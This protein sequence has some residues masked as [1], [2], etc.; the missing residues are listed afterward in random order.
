MDKLVSKA[1]K[2]GLCY[3]GPNAVANLIDYLPMMTL[4][5][6]AS[7]GAKEVI[8][9]RLKSGAPWVDFV[10]C[11]KPAMNAGFVEI[12]EMISKRF[13]DEFAYSDLFT[14][15]NNDVIGNASDDSRDRYKARKIV[16]ERG[17][18]L[19]RCISAAAIT[20][21]PKLRWHSY[22]LY[23]NKEAVATIM[24]QI[25]EYIG[26]DKMVEAI[27]ASLDEIIEKIQ[28]IIARKDTPD[29]KALPQIE[30]DISE[31][32]ITDKKFGCHKIVHAA[33]ELDIEFEDIKQKVVNHEVLI[34]ALVQFENYA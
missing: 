14:A 9:K 17:L 11:V 22:D 20:S 7:H 2:I 19:S 1:I 21:E 8:Q 29:F 33:I 34:E 25:G 12:I 5:Y 27:A 28:S 16:L 10:R 4:E 23:E 31:K 24:C 32:S 13:G 3:S 6:F 18:S 26:H 30:R 15:E